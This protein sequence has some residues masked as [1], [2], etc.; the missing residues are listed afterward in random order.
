MERQPC[1]YILASGRHGTLYIGVTSNLMARLVQHRDG[2]IE[3]FTTR[4]GVARLVWFQM[5]DTM[6][7][8][9]RREKQLK[10]WNRD[11]KLRLIEE[12]NPNWVDLAVG[13]GF[14]PIDPT[15]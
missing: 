5:A 10:K 1:V 14:D 9:I 11:W 4:Y 6:E 3:G 7:A 8:A 13:L 12:T 15:A 2:L